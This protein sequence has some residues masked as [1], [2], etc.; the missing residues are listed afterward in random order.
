M[1]KK[2]LVETRNI[3]KK[4]SSHLE[5]SGTI[6]S[7]L[8]GVDDGN[9]LYDRVQQSELDLRTARETAESALAAYLK[10]K[11]D[12]DGTEKRLL[13]L[14][15]IGAEVCSLFG[16][17]IANDVLK[18][19]AA[20]P[21]ASAVHIAHYLMR[22]PSVGKAL[23][24]GIT[25]LRTQFLEAESAIK[26][27]EAKAE[28]GSRELTGAYYQAVSVL[29]QAKAFLAVKGVPVRDRKA[30]V[31]RKRALAAVPSPAQ[32][33]ERPAAP[34]TPSPAPTPMPIPEAA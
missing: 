5:R 18:A 10:E 11:Q 29:A 28:A 27:V 6:S 24:H 17:E 15:R 25:D 8:R 22:V 30:P 20:D 33:V 12:L 31:R 7:Q 9:E 16:V 21:Q 4:L 3:I 19:D 13:G 26:P 2:K 14:I 34:T 32:P 23:A 1:D